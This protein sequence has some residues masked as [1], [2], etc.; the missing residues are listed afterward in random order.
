MTPLLRAEDLRVAFPARSGV[1]EAVRGVNFEIGREKVGLVGESGSGKSTIG[2][3]L[4]RLA[5]GIVSARRLEFAGTD[6]LRASEAEIRRLRGRRISMI[7][8]DP[9]FSL[10]PVMTVGRQVAETWRAH[11][12]GTDSEARQHARAMLES[13]GLRDWRR[14]SAAF[15]HQL[16]GG[17]GQRAMIAMMLVAEPDLLIADEPTSAIDVTVRIQV[18]SVLDEL[19]RRRG[20]GLLFISHDL[21]LVASFCDR[22]LVLYGGRILESLPANEIARH[23]YT[24]AL[25]AA[26]PELNVPRPML[27]VVPRD[28]AWLSP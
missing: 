19:V 24:R 12:Q 13:C 27:P 1:T 7:L 20:M 15:P 8:Q 23:P 5:P 16:S 28:P 11:F 26:Q 6:I 4:L 10:N 25:W 3:A 14:I 17:E 18:L 22:V 2:R 21:R 9:R